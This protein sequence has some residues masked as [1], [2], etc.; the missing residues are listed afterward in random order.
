MADV[1]RCVPAPP[2][3]TDAAAQ[4]RGPFPVEPGGRPLFG[5]FVS[6]GA[7]TYWAATGASV[8]LARTKPAAAEALVGGCVLAPYDQRGQEDR[9]ATARDDDVALRI[10]M[11]VGGRAGGR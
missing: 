4:G 2:E 8:G 9:A 1:Y 11:V 6:D 10:G 5:P 3:I 7:A